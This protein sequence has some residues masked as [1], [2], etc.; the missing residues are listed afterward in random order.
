MPA[1]E[2]LHVRFPLLDFIRSGSVATIRLFVIRN[3]AAVATR[4]LF[5]RL[6]KHASVLV[7]VKGLRDVGFGK[8]FGA[9]LEISALLQQAVFLIVII[10][11]QFVELCFVR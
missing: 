3:R 1:I 5:V 6:G 7:L 4:V 10:L 2:I 9:A 11:L 8:L